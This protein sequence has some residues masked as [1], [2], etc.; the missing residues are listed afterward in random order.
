[1]GDETL[2]DDVLDYI[3]KLIEA[4]CQNSF[5]IISKYQP[6]LVAC[7]QKNYDIV[8]SF[9]FTHGIREEVV[10][11]ETQITAANYVCKRC[12]SRNV[13]YDV[14]TADM[15]CHM[16]GTC[17]YNSDIGYLYQKQTIEEMD[18]Y[19]AYK[20]VVYSRITNMKTILRNLQSYPS[21]LPIQTLEFINQYKGSV[22]TFVEL[23]KMMKRSKL[24]HSYSKTHLIMSM[25]NP[26]YQCLK[27]TRPQHMLI[28]CKFRDI[29]HVFTTENKFHRSNFL[30]YHYVIRCISLEYDLGHVLPHLLE[31]KCRITID[32]HMYIMDIIKNKLV[33]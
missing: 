8:T 18:H 2:F 22:I 26:E 10:L 21:P 16:C 7:A 15:T 9:A 5:E 6:Y 14:I 20:K 11:T 23:R 29:L 33:Y 17:T 27:L 28:M 24:S 32:K 12:G 19:T 30:N 13:T 4:N 25:I 3:N 1:M 31:L